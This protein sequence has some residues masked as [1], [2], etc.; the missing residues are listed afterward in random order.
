MIKYTL[1]ETYNRPS[2]M[3]LQSDSLPLLELEISL[4]H[5]EI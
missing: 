4:F 2:Y 3:I 5:I 1:N